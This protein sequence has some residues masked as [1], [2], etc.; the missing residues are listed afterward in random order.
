MKKVTALIALFFAV[1]MICACSDGTNSPADAEESAVEIDANETATYIDSGHFTVDTETLFQSIEKHL[2]TSDAQLDGERESG[3]ANLFFILPMDVDEDI[4]GYIKFYKY[5]PDDQDAFP[6]EVTDTS[7]IPDIVDIQYSFYVNGDSAFDS[8]DR[9][10][11]A[12]ALIMRAVGFTDDEI[13]DD[14]LYKLAFRSIDYASADAEVGGD[15]GNTSEEE[16]NAEINSGAIKHNEQARVITLNIN[17]KQSDKEIAQR[18]ADTV[19]FGSYEQDNDTSNGKEPIEW[20]ILDRADGKTLLLSKM[21]LDYKQYNKEFDDCVWCNCSI[22]NW[23]NEDFIKEAFNTDEQKQICET[24]VVT[25]NNEEYDTP[26]GADSVDKVF[27]LSYQELFNY[28]P[29]G[30][31]CKPTA[32]AIA[33]GSEVSDDYDGKGYTSWFLRTPGKSQIDV[34]NV[35]PDGQAFWYDDVNSKSSIRPAMWVEMEQ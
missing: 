14:K 18:S 26:G 11:K 4:E 20:I 31:K 28:F 34:L 35:H 25:E 7:E 10:A 17:P 33:Q 22:R 16:G 24:N 29:K 8:M 1:I 6:D 9:A 15:A 3:A 21:A 32:Y 5:N 13:S 2:G 12:T 23:L 27:L 30:D 19:A